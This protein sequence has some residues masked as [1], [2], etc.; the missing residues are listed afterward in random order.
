ML[1]SFT[2][3]NDIGLL[4]G[5]KGATQKQMQES[6]GAKIL[7]RGKGSAKDG[8][9]TNTGHPEDDDDAL[10][11]FI[12]GNEDA[13]S[14]ATE[15]VEKIIY[16]PQQAL[17]LKNEQLRQLAGKDTDAIYGAGAGDSYQ[18]ELRVP[19]NMVGLI[20]GKGG[21][22]I[23]RIQSQLNVHAQ[24][25]KESEMK[26]GETLRSIVIKGNPSNVNEAKQR[27]DEIIDAQLAKQNPTAS[28]NSG[29]RELNCAFVVKLPVPNDKVGIIIGKGGMNIKG[30]Q[31][32]TRTQVQI[33]QQADDDNPQVR[34][35]S[36]GGDTKE[37]VDA[38]QM[39]IFMTLQ[40]QQQ[41]AQN[42]YNA[43]ANAL[44]VAVPDEKI[45]I[46]IGKGGSTV[47]DVQARLHVRIQIPQGPDIG[48]N[49]P[50]RTVRYRF[51]TLSTHLCAFY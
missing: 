19:N 50:V 2:S 22:N 47:K 25:A 4:I 42:A 43:S 24:I 3:F 32:R 33:P 48:S 40:A 1:Y 26:P 38:A 28:S 12:E 11:V 21:E 5:P 6:S 37:A 20:I 45:G 34:T 13:V 44:L 35:I 9:S 39:E 10:H 36:I 14:R 31:E 29:S 49:P 8:G 41:S 15:E 7:I 17:R 46:V 23:L 51:L 30:V 27:I 18:I 16:D